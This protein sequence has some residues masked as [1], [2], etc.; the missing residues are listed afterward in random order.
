V[1]VDDKQKGYANVTG[2]TSNDDLGTRLQK[3][4]IYN[5]NRSSEFSDIKVLVKL[6]QVVKL[7][8]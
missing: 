6:I 1:P 5:G 8:I 3:Y 4:D 7:A 2:G